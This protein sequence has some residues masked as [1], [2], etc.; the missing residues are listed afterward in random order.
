MST[1]KRKKVTREMMEKELNVDALL[2]KQ[3]LQTAIYDVTK[4]N[5]FMGSVL[6]CLDIYYTLMVERA[7]I[8]F[9]SDAKKWQMAVNPYWYCK[10]LQ[11]NNR[12]GVLL[13]EMMHITHKHPTRVPF[14]KLN[15]NR[16]HLMNVAMDMA[17]N[18]YIQDLPK[19][20]QHCPPKDVG[21]PC[22]NE[23][24]PGGGIFVEDFYDTD[25]DGN[26]VPWEKNKPME[27]YYMKL[28]KRY[29]DGDSG[30]G[31]DEQQG[32]KG[33]GGLPEEFDS[34][35][36]DSNSE[37][38]EMLDAT[39]DLVKRAI[40]KQGLS[41][42]NVPQFAKDLLESIT[43]RRAELN[44]K[45][46]I[47]AAIKK[48]ASGFNREN[49]RTRPSRR[50]KW[51]APGTKNGKLPKVEFMID[52]SGSIS[53]Q[54]ANDFL[55]I[56]DEFMKVGSRESIL[57]LWH[58]QVYYTE[59]HKLHKGV[60]KDAWQ[61]GGTDV[62]PVIETIIERQPDLA[63]VLTDGCYGDVDFE[64]MLRPGQHMPQILWIISKDGWE[65]HPLKRTGET[66]KI[67]NTE[68]LS[69]DKNL[70]QL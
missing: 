1:E 29:E 46:L 4:S 24:C 61:S 10:L 36:W 3:S 63:I 40:Q 33:D 37:E 30:E 23:K 41:Y 69:R 22:K 11:K 44:Y 19:G 51:K 70:E 25:K 6:Q 50:Y 7:G 58:T 64:H 49:T 5:P 9:N 66:I 48:N 16:R 45:Q 18:Q 32:G 67:P 12:K 56:G 59:K 65:D 2:K 54:E 28:I 57:H 15:P 60:P 26:R 34:H 31:G 42:D 21:G 68:Q 43:A 35:D 13:H 62:T 14:L 8:M 55:D 52:T 47:L 17:I 53:V 27:F 38:N 39:E 20:C